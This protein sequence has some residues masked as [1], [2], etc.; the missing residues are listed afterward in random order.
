MVVCQRPVHLPHIASSLN[1]TI[2]E[3]ACRI[4]ETGLKKYKEKDADK[5]ELDDLDPLGS[6]IR[7]GYF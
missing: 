7:H 4:I 1:F 6:D 2:S 5:D 3:A